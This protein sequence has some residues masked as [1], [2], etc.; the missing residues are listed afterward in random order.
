MTKV[1]GSAD[2]ALVGETVRFTVTGT[3]TG[4][5]ALQNVTLTDTFPTEYLQYLSVFSGNPAACP[6]TAP[7]TVTCSAGTVTP[8]AVGA[9]GSETVSFELSFRALK[10][11]LPGRAVNS[12]VLSG[13]P[14]GSGPGA[15]IQIGPATADV[16]IIDVKGL[17]LPPLGDG[18]AAASGTSGRGI[19][20]TTLA[21]GILSLVP[22]AVRRR[23]L[24]SARNEER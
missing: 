1:R 14:D 18:S 4:D 11:T 3:I 13:D 21:F 20:L 7:G 19:A 17:Q 16:Q 5:T 8:G 10:S 2:P 12:V 22:V 23:Q 24:R 6:L 9:P 15:P